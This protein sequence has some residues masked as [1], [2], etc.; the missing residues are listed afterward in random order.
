MMKK[1]AAAL[2]I[3][4]FVSCTKEEKEDYESVCVE[5]TL[6]YSSPALDGVGWYIQ[7]NT[8]TSAKF[9]MILENSIPDSVRSNNLK[10]ATC[11]EETNIRYQYV[12]SATP[13]DYNYYKIT[14]IRKL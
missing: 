10:V 4:T 7:V 2:L 6:M 12:M 3:L 8:D 14:T 11:L 5:G 13:S 9:Y 1:L